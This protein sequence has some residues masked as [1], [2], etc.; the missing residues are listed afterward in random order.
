MSATSD[1]CDALLHECDIAV[2]LC[3]KL[4]EGSAEYRPAPEQRSML[5]LLRYLAGCGIG[6]ARAMRDGDWA[7]YK[8]AME[9]VAEMT[10]E[11]FPDAMRLQKDELT[12]LF[13]G[14]G[15]DDL[16]TCEATLPWGEKVTLRR[17]LV[18]TTLKWL[19]A[20]RMQLFLY[21]K[22]AGNTSIGTANNWAGVDDKEE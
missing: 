19:T 6:S 8:A 10:V 20:Y 4:P 1:L 15:D 9:R 17:A 2:H 12:A 22:A 14:L 3:S 16:A 11:G 18:E 7:G 5:E 21:A 13:A